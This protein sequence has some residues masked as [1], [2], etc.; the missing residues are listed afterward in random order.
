MSKFL[1]LSDCGDG[2]GLALRL[3]AEGHSVKTNIF[4]P[5]FEDQGKGLVEFAD[6]YVFGQTVIADVTGFGPILEK[7]RDE[8]T[9][10]FSGGSFADKLEKDRTLAQEVMDEV[11]IET[12][13]A[14]SA[15]SWEDAARLVEE[16]GEISERIVIKPEGSLSGVVPS[17]CASSVEDGLAMLE[18]FKREHGQA[19][20]SMTI[21]EFVE[22]IAV[23]TEGWFTGKDWAEGMFNHTIERKH[24]LN[25]DKGPSGGCTGN[26]VWKCDSDDPLVTKT[27][28]KLTDVLRK[29]L[30]VGPIDV[31]CI[32]N[33]EGVYGLEFTPRF[34]YDAFPTLLYTLCDFDFGRFIDHLSHHVDSGD[35][36][37]EGFGAGVRLSLPPW[38]NEKFKHDGGVQIRG[39]DDLEDRALFYP[40]GVSL[41]D[42]KLASCQGVGI[43]GV[44]NGHAASITGAFNRCYKL[45]DKIS[46]PDL[47][48]RT[49]LAKVFTK[50]FEELSSLVSGELV[51]DA[52]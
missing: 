40:Y 50:D 39:L 32:V 36:L 18:Q 37:S 17:Y 5:S 46:A 26:V 42:D 33:K 35:A 45:I 10:I 21:Q 9:P 29:H 8:G 22:G 1:L 24:F 2:V 44:V 30:Y 15:E 38:P 27:L 34:G 47:Q 49:D 4:N 16:F 19:E 41:Q 28:L 20:C 51:A 7:L 31:N 43:L 14:Q 12:P 25:D 3:Q 48:Y 11:G 23:S 52:S 13:K 6:D